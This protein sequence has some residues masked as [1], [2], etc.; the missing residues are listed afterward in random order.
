[1]RERQSRM[2]TEATLP[3]TETLLTGDDVLPGF[4]VSVD[5]FFEE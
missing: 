1:M 3:Q 4:S 5:K 2:A